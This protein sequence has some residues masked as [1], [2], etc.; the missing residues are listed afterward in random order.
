MNGKSESDQ[1]IEAMRENLRFLRET[2]GWTI[3]ELSKKSRIRV[4]V[5]HDM[6]GGR[7]FDIIYLIRLCK[8]Y[9]I[10]PYKL[11]SGIIVSP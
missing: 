10:E 11:F 3:E 5:L 2:H 6:E 7:D 4:K 1:Q 9:N 8:L